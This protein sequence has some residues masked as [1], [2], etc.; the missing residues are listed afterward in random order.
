VENHTQWRDG[1]FKH[2]SL[3]SNLLAPVGPDGSFIE[4]V[5]SLVT[6]TSL[7]ETFHA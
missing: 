1:F 6:K 7:Y 4:R 3:I 5:Y 2:T